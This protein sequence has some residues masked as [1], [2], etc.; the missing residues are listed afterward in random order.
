MLNLCKLLLRKCAHYECKFGKFRISY[1]YEPVPGVP[2]NTCHWNDK[3][4]GLEVF[5][6]CREM[7]MRLRKA[8]C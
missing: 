2:V 4:L 7:G 8:A 3:S 6:H 1:E 5:W